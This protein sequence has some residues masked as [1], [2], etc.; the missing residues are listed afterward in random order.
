MSNTSTELKCIHFQKLYDLIIAQYEKDVG[1]NH[2]SLKH[3]YSKYGYSDNYDFEKEPSIKKKMIEKYIEKFGKDDFYSKFPKG[4][5]NGKYLYQKKYELDNSSDIIKL[6]NTYLSVYLFYVELS[7]VRELEDFTVLSTNESSKKGY[8][9]HFRC[10]F[11]DNPFIYDHP[12]L[13]RESYISYLLLSIKEDETVEILNSPSGFI[14]Q[15]K[16]E[17][18]DMYSEIVFEAMK[19]NKKRKGYMVIANGN[20]YLTNRKASIGVYLNM[21]R[22]MYPV[23]GVIIFEKISNP[24]MIS[25]EEVPLVIKEY[26]LDKPQLRLTD[27]DIFSIE[28]IRRK[29]D[30]IHTGWEKNRERIK[31]LLGDYI[32]YV[33]DVYDNTI[34]PRLVQGLLRVNAN[35][36]VNFKSIGFL[37]FIGEIKVINYNKIVINMK[38][39]GINQGGE[40]N[41]FLDSTLEGEVKFLKGVYAGINRF[42]KIANGGIY[43]IKMDNE[44][45]E[46]EFKKF[47]G[48]YIDLLDSEYQKI[49]IEHPSIKQFFNNEVGAYNDD[50]SFQK[51]FQNE[52]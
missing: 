51:H 35:H 33:T 36:T 40:F 34:K 28:A 26:L 23:Y 9:A 13:D 49:I 48:R 5:F 25:I 29:L 10:Y 47:Q 38:T 18:F 27:N 19:G 15:G 12:F 50:I 39:I 7:E 20:E 3:D 32:F 2:H 21:S 16:L 1:K 22:S 52:K 44:L 6:R 17:N 30:K 45:S 24:S 31:D 37:E 11:K 14:Y 41:I 42:F 4:K 43:L 8:L 46:K